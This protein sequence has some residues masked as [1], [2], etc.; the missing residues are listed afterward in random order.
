[1]VLSSIFS[2]TTTHQRGGASDIVSLVVKNRVFLAKIFTNLLVQLATTYYVMEKYSFPNKKWPYVI[3]S[4]IL[5]LIIAGTN[6]PYWAKFFVFI[7]FSYTI[8]R[9]FA[10]YKKKYSEDVIR[11]AILGAMGIFVIMFII[12]GLVP[13]LGPKV[14]L[15]LFIALLS[16]LIVRIIGMFSDK[17]AAYKKWISGAGIGIFGLYVVYDTNNILKRADYYQGDFITASLDYYLDIIN[18]FSELTNR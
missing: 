4:I 16:L 7:L 17:T 6:L 11:G 2:T 18:L 10:I 13:V 1:M 12:G 8:G 5:V 15:A 3:G 9:I 14:G